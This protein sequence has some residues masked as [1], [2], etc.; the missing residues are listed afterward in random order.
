MRWL[1]GRVR[2]R[3]EEARRKGRTLSISRALERD[4]IE[5]M[6]R[7]HEGQ[8]TAAHRSQAKE[9]AKA[10]LPRLKTA[11]SIWRRSG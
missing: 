2:F 6:R 10:W 8:W 1:D 4:M 3:Q 11:L 5:H 9:L 7:Q